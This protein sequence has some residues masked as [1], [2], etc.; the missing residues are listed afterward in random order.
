MYAYHVMTQDCNTCDRLV[1][2]A[3]FSCRLSKQLYFETRECCCRSRYLLE[4]QK[5]L[6]IKNRQMLPIVSF[7]DSVKAA[8]SVFQKN[9]TAAMLVYQDNPVGIDL[10]SLYVLFSQ[11]R[12]RD[13]TLGKPFLSNFV[14]FTCISTHNLWKDNG[15]SSPETGYW[16]NT[17]Y[18]KR[19][20]ELL[21]YVKTFNVRIN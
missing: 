14:L 21:S 4:L 13:N 17:T 18:K 5:G 1:L 7:M 11:Y 19:F 3:T 6:R 15:P 2:P 9:E 10:F 16:E 12:S 20:I 8:V